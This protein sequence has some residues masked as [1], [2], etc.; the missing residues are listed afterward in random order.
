MTVNPVGVRTYGTRIRARLATQIRRKSHCRHSS[1]FRSK[2]ILIH[3][4]KERRKGGGLIP[5][6]LKNGATFR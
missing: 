2:V 3:A 1:K 4:M 5:L 6:I